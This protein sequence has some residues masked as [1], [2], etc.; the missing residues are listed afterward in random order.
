MS[1]DQ[2]TQNPGPIKIIRKIYSQFGFDSFHPDSKSCYPERLEIECKELHG[3]Q[4][5]KFKHV[6]IDDELKETI[7]KRWHRQFEVLGYED[8]YDVSQ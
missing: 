4:R 3:Y 8:I 6:V 2:L 7:K 5:N 1:F